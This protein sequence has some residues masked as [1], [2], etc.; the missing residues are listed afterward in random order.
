MRLHQITETHSRKKATRVGRGI[1]AGQG[2]TAGRG[3]KGQKSRTGANSNIPRTFA[4][5]TTPMVQRLPKLKGFTSHRVKPIAINMIRLTAHFEDG[6]TIS[7]AALA[8][9]NLITAKDIVKGIKIVGASAPIEKKYTFDT[10]DARLHLSK[11]LTPS[12]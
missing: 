2:K 4:G 5:G 1:A 6:A 7:I 12:A 10:S 9:K 11:S 8:E 3:T